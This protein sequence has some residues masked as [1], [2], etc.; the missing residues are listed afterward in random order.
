MNQ[1][2]C[3]LLFIFSYS[4]QTKYLK[5]FTKFLGL[6]RLKLVFRSLKRCRGNQFFVGFIH[7]TEFRDIQ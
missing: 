6:I 2:R 1:S 7:G 4:C 3:A 5:I